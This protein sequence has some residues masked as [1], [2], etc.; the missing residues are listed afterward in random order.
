[1]GP[2]GPNPEASSRFLVTSA[3]SRHSGSAGALL[4]GYFIIFAYLCKEPIWIDTNIKSFLRLLALYPQELYNI[5]LNLD[6]S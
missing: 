4:Y 2:P 1:M 5:D 6:I 3:R